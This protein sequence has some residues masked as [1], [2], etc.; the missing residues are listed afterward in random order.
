[1]A[2]YFCRKNLPIEPQWKVENRKKK[3]EYSIAAKFSFWR[4]TEN[5]P[6]KCITSDGSGPKKSS[7]GRAQALNV[8][9]GPGLEPFLQGG[10]TG[11]AGRAC[12]AQ[13]FTN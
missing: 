13:S 7:P 1:M 2:I 4:E 12:R 6:P 11:Q 9:L 8:K 3:S 10:A 5:G